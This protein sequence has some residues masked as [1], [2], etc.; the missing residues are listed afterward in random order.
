MRKIHF[1]FGINTLS[2]AVKAFN[3][4]NPRDGG[5]SITIKS[6]VSLTDANAFFNIVSRE[7]RK[8]VLLQHQLVELL[9]APQIGFQAL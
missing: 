2:A 1:E 4:N 9:Q 5:Q 6:Y 3:V 8:L 7:Q